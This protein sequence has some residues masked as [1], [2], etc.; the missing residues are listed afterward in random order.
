VITDINL[1]SLRSYKD[2]SFEFSPGVNIIIGPNATG[3]TNLLEAVLVAAKGSSFRAKD[4]ELISFSS[5]WARIET[6]DQ[7]SNSRIVL[8]KREGEHSQKQFKINGQTLKRLTLEKSLPAVVFE[9]NH[10]QLLSGSPELRRQ[11]LDGILEQTQIGY[12][13]LLRQYRRVLGQ[14]NNLLKKGAKI[15]SDQLFVWNVRISELGEQIARARFEL[16][17]E[18]GKDIQGLYNKLTNSSPTKLE[19]SYLSLVEPER[20]ATTLL[21]KLETHQKEDIERG[22]TVYGPHREDLKI[23]INGRPALG[24]ASR[25]ETRTL[26][27]VFKMIEAILVERFRNARPLL[28]FDDVFSEL[29]GKRRQAL[30]TF[31]QSYQ[32]F[33]TTTD[34]DVVIQHF[35]QTCNIIPL[36]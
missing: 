29:D 30:T 14:R 22:F 16:S 6:H 20:Y 35:T 2:D 24:T 28:L 19:I 12:G 5:P 31:L 7:S 8:I 17:K 10:L 11:F 32:T 15:A 33:I 36:A 26:V 23:T 4:I 13:S 1:Q 3:K 27:L 21:R 9:P 18:I 34:A 25:G